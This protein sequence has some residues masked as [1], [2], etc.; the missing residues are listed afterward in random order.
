MSIEGLISE[1]GTL[2]SSLLAAIILIAALVCGI[3][4]RKWNDEDKLVD[5]RGVIEMMPSLISTLGV[6]F[7]FAGIALGLYFFNDKDLT[8]SIPQL[9]TGLKTAFFTSLAGM[10]GSM[11]LSGQVNKLFDKKTGG[12]SDSVEAAGLIVKELNTLTIQNRE[13]NNSM[14]V[15]MKEKLGE[16]SERQLNT[17][18]NS[19]HILNSIEKQIGL[20]SELV[21]KAAV[22]STANDNAAKTLERIDIS[23]KKLVDLEGKHYDNSNT[24]KEKQESI[25]S[26]AESILISVGNI[27]E[28]NNAILSKTIEQNNRVGEMMDHTEA[29]VGGQDEISKHVSKFGEILH[30]EI[31][32]IEEKMKDTNKLLADKFEEFAELLRK[33]NTEAL[34]EVMKKVTEEFQKQMNALINKLIQENFEQLNK[35]V[36]RLNTWQQENKEMIASL[37]SQYKQMAENFENTSTSLAKVDEDT[38]HLVSEGGKLHQI[39]NLLNQVI[40]EDEKFLKISSDLQNTAK[41]TKTN[42]EQFD[43]ST[44]SLNDWVKKQRKFVDAVVVLIAKLDELN[45]IRDYGEQFWKETKQSMNEGVS[46]IKDGTEA[47]N[48]QVSSLNRQFYNRLST[49]LTE[50]DNCI[51]ALINR[52]EDNTF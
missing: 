20:L 12:V 39:V 4:I 27:E 36:E 21:S 23:S 6:F 32:E 33:S 52:A 13:Y 31:V 42:F 14:L 3:L 35:S 49:T 26:K 41:L 28:S 8:T 16:L 29:L 43:E 9:L 10:T 47:L 37:T 34:V 18:T 1:H 48:S 46:I 30:G 2:V 51:Q 24:I 50:L 7:T 25:E 45:K 19:N 40:V 44:R 5:H 11:L 15:M 17:Y 38:R 22:L